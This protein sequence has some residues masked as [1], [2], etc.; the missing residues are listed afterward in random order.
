MARKQDTLPSAYDRGRQV[1]AIED[2]RMSR[3]VR[4]VL[5]VLGAVAVL[6]GAVAWGIEAEYGSGLDYSIVPRGDRTYVYEEQ[7]GEEP[8][9][10]GSREEA[11]DYMER[12]RAAGESFVLPG[13]VIAG[14]A[15]LLIVVAFAGRRTERTA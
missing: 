14:G 7:A 11:F 3:S 10:V 13:A 8:V 6:G 4:I 9:F 2:L 5:I 1:P 15:I 12:S